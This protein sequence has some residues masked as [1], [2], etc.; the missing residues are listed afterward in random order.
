[1]NKGKTTVVKKTMKDPELIKLFNQMMGSGEADPNIIIPKYENIYNTAMEVIKILHKFST[2]PVSLVVG[3]SFPK[4]FSDIQ[5]FSQYWLSAIVNHML[6]ENE[7]I[8]SGMDLKEINSDPDKIMQ[9]LSDVQSKYKVAGL[10]ERYKEFKES[11]IIKELILLARNLQT[12]VQTEKERSKSKTHCLEHKSN[13][14]DGFIVNCDGDY[15]TLFGFS[16]LDF[17]QL[18]YSETMTEEYKKYVLLTLHYIYIR[19][20][21]IV[22]EVTS[23]D[24][25]VE[26]LSEKIVDSV[27]DLRKH[28]P[29]CDLAFNKI[30]N[31][32]GMLKNNFGEYYKDFVTSQSGH[33]GIIVENFVIDVAK[34]QS[35]DPETAR[36]FRTIVNFYKSRM[37]SGEIKDPQMK[38]MLELVQ[39]NLGILEGKMAKTSGAES[40]TPA[41]DSESGEKEAEPKPS[42]NAKKKERRK[43]ESDINNL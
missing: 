1:M 7:G 43:R 16:C 2:N 26:R 8:F 40:S 29:R 5:A 42:K 38:H 32:V 39:Q 23:P 3:K 30:K 36:Q 18:F 15:L 27:D 9:M 4:G 24:V 41:E 10:G 33:P 28:I 20:M 13:L 25:D 19:V 21:N 17:K 12:A 34:S 31:S 35:S 37:S 6:E 22:R 14:T 11:K